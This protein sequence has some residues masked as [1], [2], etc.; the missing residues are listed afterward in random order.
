MMIALLLSLVTS[1]RM[2]QPLDEMARRRHEV[3]TRRASPPASRMTDAPTRSA[4]SISAFNTMA[5]SLENSRGAPQRVHRQRLARAQDADDHHRRL[6]RRHA[7]RHDPAKDQE[8][9]Y[10]VTDRRRD[11][12]PLAPCAQH[13]GHVAR[14][15]ARARI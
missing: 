3:R 9:K 4:R 12:P 10:L 2:A 11:A 5:D 14:C 6:C 8:D 13:A 7:R 1:K 15:R